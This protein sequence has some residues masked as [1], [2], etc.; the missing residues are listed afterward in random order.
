MAPRRPSS[1]STACAADDSGTFALD[2]VD[3]GIESCS[4]QRMGFE[5]L[6]SGFDHMLAIF[7]KPVAIAA[8]EL[9]LML[10][11]FLVHRP[12]VVH[13]MRAGH[14]RGKFRKQVRFGL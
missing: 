4:I 5:E 11:A 6:R 14:L 8:N 3:I 1:L 7:E 12:D 10:G 13:G 2:K 9:D